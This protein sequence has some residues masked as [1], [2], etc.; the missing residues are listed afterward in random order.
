MNLDQYL[1]ALRSDRAFMS[2][3]THWETLPAKD[4]RVMD[5][6]SGL[7]APIVR[8][9]NKRGIYQLYTHQ[10]QAVDAALDG[11]NVT[12]VTPTASGKTLC[13]NLPVLEAILR[14]RNTRALYLFPTKALSADQ[15]AELNQFIADMGEEVK[16]FT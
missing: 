4:A 5:I 8:A 9:L 15:N 7:S 2:C 1:E 6:S 16:A 11:R 14:D 12:I 13:Y 10:R 3:V